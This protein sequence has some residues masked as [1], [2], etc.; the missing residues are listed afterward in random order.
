MGWISRGQQERDHQGLR[1]VCAACGHP[2]TG[3]DPMVLT[4]NNPDWGDV[5]TGGPR[6]HR[7]HTT[8][9]NSGLYGLAQ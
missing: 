5:A 6:V 4:T 2:F 9:P 7:S 3:Q 1:E 8:D